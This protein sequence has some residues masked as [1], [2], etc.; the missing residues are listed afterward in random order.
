M[1]VGERRSY[2]SLGKYLSIEHLPPRPMKSA[3][4]ISIM[5]IANQ[6]R[7]VRSERRT[8]ALAVAED[9]HGTTAVGRQ[10]EVQREDSQIDL[11]ADQISYDL[12]RGPIGHM[13]HLHLAFH[14][15]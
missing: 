9:L 15:D 3:T 12:R 4:A 11:V 13:H 7:Q 5:N 14:I 1:P 6:A 8:R 2:S 10:G